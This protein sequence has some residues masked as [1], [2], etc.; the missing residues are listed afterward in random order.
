MKAG[1][2]RCLLV[3]EVLK[4]CGLSETRHLKHCVTLAWA[5]SVYV[6]RFWTSRVQSRSWV[7]TRSMTPRCCLVTLERWH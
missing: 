2:W 6:C 7:L 5:D 1:C 3:Q 4:N